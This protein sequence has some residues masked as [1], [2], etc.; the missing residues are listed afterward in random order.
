M[1]FGILKSYI[2]DIYGFY[3]EKYM[4]GYLLIT[5]IALTGL[6]TN[7]EAQKLR[8]SKRKLLTFQS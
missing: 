7:K 1:F 4:P 2:I 5:A 8:R 6:F 3:F